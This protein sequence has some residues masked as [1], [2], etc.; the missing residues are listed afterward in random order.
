MKRRPE[1]LVLAVEESH[2]VIFLP[3]ILDKDAAPACMYLAGLHQRLR[4]EGRT[5][6]DYY[7]SILEE[8]GGFDTVNRSIMMAGASGMERKDRIMTWLREIARPARWVGTRCAASSTTGTK[9]AVRTAGQRERAAAAQRGPAR[10]RSVRGHGAA[11]GH[12]AEAQVLLSAPARKPDQL[13]VGGPAQRYEPARPSTAAQPCAPRRMRPPGRS[14]TI[15]C[16]R[17]V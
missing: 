9:S 1:E 14:T 15:C 10:H 5:L 16:R 7:V 17:S 6:L 13:R 2:G 3:H 12:R 8:L 11:L 4:G